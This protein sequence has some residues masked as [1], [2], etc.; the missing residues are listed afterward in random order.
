MNLKI[1]AKGELSP[2]FQ[3]MAFRDFRRDYD[4]LNVAIDPNM[5]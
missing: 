3:N 2:L 5:S 1:T 4:N